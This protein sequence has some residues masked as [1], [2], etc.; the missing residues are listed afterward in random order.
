M[1][2]SNQRFCNFLIV[3]W[4]LLS[5]NH[6]KLAIS[7]Q[8]SVIHLPL[9]PPKLSYLWMKCHWGPENSEKE[10]KYCSGVNFFPPSYSLHALFCLVFECEKTACFCTTLSCTFIFFFGSVLLF[11]AYATLWQAEKEYISFTVCSLTAC[12]LKGLVEGDL[13]KSVKTKKSFLAK[14]DIRAQIVIKKGKR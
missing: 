8:V 2:W 12:Y 7:Y 4:N 3:P 5:S 1:F 6:R 10:R 13:W 9:P 11:E 14:L